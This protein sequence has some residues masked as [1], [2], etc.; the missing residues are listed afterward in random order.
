MIQFSLLLSDAARLD[1]IEAFDWYNE[2]DRNLAVSLEVH[3]ESGL[4]TIQNNPNLFQKRYK[5]TR[6]HF[7]KRFPYGI[8]YFIDG[9]TI[10][11]IGF[12]HTSRS[13]R[14]WQQRHRAAAPDTKSP[15]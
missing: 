2:I 6:V 8:H 9:T 13:P 11:V 12:F 15:H 4:N 14:R 7:I 10:R 1:I 3:I 5:N